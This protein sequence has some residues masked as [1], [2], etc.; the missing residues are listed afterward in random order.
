MPGRLVEEG[1]TRRRVRRP[2]PSLYGRPAALPAA[3]AGSARTTGGSTPFPGFLPASGADVTGCVFADRC[4]LADDRCRHRIAAAL[5][6]ARARTARAAATTPTGRRTCRAPRRPR[7]P[8]LQPPADS[9]PMLRCSA[10]RLAKTFDAG[11]HPVRAVHDVS[12]DL[13]P[14]R[15][16]GWSANP[17]AARRRSPGC[18]WAC[19][20]PDAGGTHRARRAAAGPTLQ[21][22]GDEQ[23]KALQIVFQNPDSALNRVAF[24]APHRSA[25]R[26]TRLARSPRR[27][28][29]GA[30]AD[31]STRGGAAGR[32]LSRRAS[33]ASCRAG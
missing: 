25:A 13:G 1:P 11:G 8:P 6:D 28:A 12:L 7:S 22:R 33:R 21:I 9:A 23:L 2:A 20:P 16:W 17:A 4:A 30:P 26:S 29:R 24:G 5:I 32:P 3:R 10:G 31:A 18:C 14:A 19:S 27:R 15:R